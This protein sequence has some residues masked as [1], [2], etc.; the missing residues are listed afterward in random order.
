MACA[1]G[2]VDDGVPELRFSDEDAFV[3]A[4]ESAPKNWVPWKSSLLAGSVQRGVAS[5]VGEIIG[6]LHQATQ[7]VEL[8][9]VGMTDREPFEQLR[10][11]PYYE[12]AAKRQPRWSADLKELADELRSNRTCMVHGDLSPKNV[13]APPE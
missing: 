11:R 8:L 12:Y 13:L 3:L 5:R 9:S 4:I 7:D 1:R 10:L 2:L 6:S